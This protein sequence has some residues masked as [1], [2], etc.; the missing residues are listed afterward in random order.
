MSNR[1]PDD[2]VSRLQ[3]EI[4]ALLREKQTLSQQVKR[5]IKAEGRL[6]SLQEALDSQ[7]KEYKEL[8][9]LNKRINATKELGAVLRYT[10]E[11][12]V[13][14]L[15]YE[16]AIFFL[17]SRKRL[18]YRAYAA[19]GFY[20]SSEKACISR[21][22]ME[23]DDPLLRP[24]SEG[25][26]YLLCM[27][28][29]QDQE[30]VEHRQRLCMDEYL[31][32]PLGPSASP[33]ALLTVGNSA[34]NAKF[35]RL[36]SDAN[37]ELLGMGNLVGLI[38]STLENRFYYYRMNKA[39]RQEMLTEAKYR[40]IFEGSVEGIFR[41]TPAGRYL[42]VNPSMARMLGY[43][44]ASELVATTG[45]LG[46]ALFAQPQRQSEILDMLRERGIIEGCEAQ[47]YRKDGS[48]IW[49]SISARTVCGPDGGMLYYEGTALNIT[50]RKQAEEALRQSEQRYRLLND[51]LGERIRETVAELRSKD[52]ILMIQN[53]QAL[54]G[55]MI[56]NIAHQWR[57]PLNM[58]G[59][60]AQELP[61]VIRKGT[62]DLEFF[63]SNSKKTME[64]I[65]YMSKTIDDF[66]NFFRPNKDKVEFKVIE[67][68]EKAVSIMQGS[69]KEH[70]IAIVI[71]AEGDPHKLGYAN[72]FSQ[73]IVNLVNNAKDAFL[74]KR[75]EKPVVSIG[76]CTKEGKTFVTVADN[77]GGIP[78]EILDKV[79]EPYF[80]TKGP[81]QGTG[82]GL[83]MSKTIIEKNMNGRLS[84]R[85]L[86]DGAEFRIEI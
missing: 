17:R 28:D 25:K 48:V 50:E 13:K 85:N 63:E 84:A 1:P 14:K 66:G 33:I 30:M 65:Q 80:T 43:A 45:E 56:N 35:Y 24:L 36:V 39:I 5:L 75:V 58:L 67:A 52:K 53:R 37:G 26:E 86:K 19:E 15:E 38:S 4:S 74:R 16:K 49:A 60:L 57:Q 9:Q 62:F 40:G 27:R 71:N 29:T 2:A 6:Y 83:F 81:G 21:L 61:V 76:V 7:L 42:E 64:I 59:L 70:Q 78:E 31:V 79:F 10:V 8:Y 20:D 77:A 3:E 46:L 41:R 11:Y 72:E 69:L 55:E 51:H 47:I 23:T 68:I 22:E 34:E 73:V 44:C 82:I 32:Y 54:M 12:A 18:N